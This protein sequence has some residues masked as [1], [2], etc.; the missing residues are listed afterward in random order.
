MAHS[1]KPSAVERPIIEALRTN[2]SL[3]V[4]VDRLRYWFGIGVPR[5]TELVVEFASLIA[6]L[7]PRHTSHALLV[8]AGAHPERF[9]PKLIGGVLSMWFEREFRTIISDPEK[10]ARRLSERMSRAGAADRRAAG[11]PR[12][13]T[14]ISHDLAAAGHEDDARRFWTHGLLVAPRFATTDF[15]EGQVGRL[16]EARER[17]KEATDDEKL[18]AI[19]AGYIRASQA[20][21]RDTTPFHALDVLCGRT[22]SRPLTRDEA[23][24]EQHRLENQRSRQ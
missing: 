23:T 19:R 7:G 1:A 3:E 13:G 20:L 12:V 16:A 2:A 18:A 21:R 10:G 24:A 17:L 15:L 9:D 22:A 11:A 4:G 8:L 14:T 5:D 6:E